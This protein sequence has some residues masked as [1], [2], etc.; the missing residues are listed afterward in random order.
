MGPKDYIK[1]S[2]KLLSYCF[3]KILDQ[4]GTKKIYYL[5]EIINLLIINL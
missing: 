4:V 5:I 2:Q 3:I 1:F